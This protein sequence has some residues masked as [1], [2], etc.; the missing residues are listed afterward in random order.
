MLTPAPGRVIVE[1]VVKKQEEGGLLI[2]DSIDKKYYEAKI[3]SLG[4]NTG[5]FLRKDDLVLVHR[6]AGVEVKHENKDFI[7]IKPEEILA[8]VNFASM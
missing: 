3:V 2:P 5:S 6:L 7:I 8:V 1:K 4:E